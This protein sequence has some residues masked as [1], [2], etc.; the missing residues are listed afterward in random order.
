MA[1]QLF[2]ATR[3]IDRK[4]STLHFEI[5]ADSVSQMLDHGGG[6]AYSGTATVVWDSG[7]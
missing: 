6:S 2:L 4:P 3:Y 5:K 7:L 1:A